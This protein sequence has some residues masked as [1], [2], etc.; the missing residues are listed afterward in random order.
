MS[1]LAIKGGT[2][3][4]KDLRI[5]PWPIVTDEDKQAVMK[6]L[7]ARQW[8]LGPVV[9]EFAQAMAK[10]HDAKHC[11]AVANGTVALELPLKAVGVR[12]GDEVIVPAVT[13]IATASAVSEVGAVP[14]FADMDPETAQLSPAAV[15]AAITKRTAAV[16]GV[17]YGGYPFDLDAVGEICKKRGLK[18][19]EDC[20][21]AQGT[22]WRGRKVGAQGDAGGMSTQASKAL[23]S[24]EGGVMLTNS[25]KVYERALLIHNIGR[26]PGKPGYEHHVLSSNYRLHEMQGALLLSAVKRLPAEVELRHRNGEWLAAELTKIGG[27][28]PLKRDPRVTQR[29]HYFLIIRYDAQQFGGVHRDKFLAALRAEGVSGGTAYGYPLYKNPCFQ[30]KLV[31]EVLWHARRRLPDYEKMHLPAAEK[32]C[33]EQQITLGHPLLMADRSELQK[34]V[35]AIVKI[36]ANVDELRTV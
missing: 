15:E 17:H 16:L 4:A 14:I 31:R 25:D 36:K 11:I 20:A 21:H 1:N 22:E 18:L 3:A 5:P 27:V 28:E 30:R 24:G 13:F 32:F 10:Y 33:A 7:E 35:D 19:V 29:G 34:V 12:P 26:V 2:P 23:A 9:R 6:A 8:C